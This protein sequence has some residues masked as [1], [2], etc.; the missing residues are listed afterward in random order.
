MVSTQNNNMGHLLVDLPLVTQW[1]AA[2]AGGP[3][4]PWMQMTGGCVP[5]IKGS[6]F[7]AYARV[8]EEQC[9]F[10]P[11]CGRVDQL[12]TLTRILERYG[13]FLIQST[14]VLWAWRRQT[15]AFLGM[16]FRGYYGSM[17][18]QSCLSVQPDLYTTSVRVCLHPWHY[19][20]FLGVLGWHC[21]SL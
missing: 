11:G 14:W 10:H 21:C 3:C 8:L 7:S 20:K 4:G 13:S 12:Y 15:T 9:G 19:F 16:S 18:H 5:I 6:Q 17:G 1:V 2:G